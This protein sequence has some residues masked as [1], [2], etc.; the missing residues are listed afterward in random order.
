MKRF[1]VSKNLF[2]K[3]DP[4]LLDNYEISG[5]NISKANGWFVS[6]FIPVNVGETYTKSSNGNQYLIYNE[7]KEKISQNSFVDNVT[8]IDTIGAKYIRINSLKTNLDSY[9]LNSGSTA[10][11]YE[12]YGDTW[13]TKSPPKYVNGTWVESNPKQRDNG[14]WV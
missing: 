13:Q 7:N 6:G 4:E 3:N 8:T 5:G 9:M 10:L 1:H 14:Q 12:P 11:P 2:D